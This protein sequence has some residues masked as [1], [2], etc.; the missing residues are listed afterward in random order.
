VFAIA[1]CPAPNTSCASTCL[2]NDRCAPAPVVGP[3]PDLRQGQAGCS[4]RG[5]R[6]RGNTAD[7]QGFQRARP[8]YPS[9]YPPVP[10]A[11]SHSARTGGLP[12]CGSTHGTCRS[13]NSIILYTKPP[14]H[15][16]S[17]GA[18]WTTFCTFF[19]VSSR[20][21]EV[22]NTNIIFGRVRR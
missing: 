15:L 3:A 14:M 16:R 20:S 8:C 19:G 1:T 18:Y 7:S 11:H 2:S 21:D 4:K 17:R 6:W 9:A 10:P 12:S 13:S 22:D 5:S